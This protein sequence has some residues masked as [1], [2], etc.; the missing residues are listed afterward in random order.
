MYGAMIR[1]AI[2]SMTRVQKLA[3]KTIAQATKG[4]EIRIVARGI[5][6]VDLPEGNHRLNDLATA[7]SG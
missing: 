6:W 5:L 3:M 4:F 7:H 1:P 2:S